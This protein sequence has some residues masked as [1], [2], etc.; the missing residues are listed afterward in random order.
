MATSEPQLD[1]LSK[2]LSSLLADWG[3]EISTVLRALEAQ[4]A[5]A[6]TEREKAERLTAKVASQQELIATL[7]RDLQAADRVKGES[8]GNDKELA[9]LR[10]EHE[11]MRTELVARK[12]LVKSLR[13]DAERVKALEK[14]L[15]EN[16]EVIATMKESIERHAK[17][18]AE[19]RRSSDSWERKYQR[20]ADAGATESSVDS[21]VFSETAVAEFLDDAMGAEP[22]H[23]IVIDMTEPLRAARDER[24]KKRK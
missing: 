9:K 5:Q 22:D 7:R 1:D 3:K 16:R 2:R 20:L 24:S 18:I 10:K 4:K 12:T 14:E 23:T 17:T 8:Q 21:N 11:A 13:A 19:L 15:D 6:A